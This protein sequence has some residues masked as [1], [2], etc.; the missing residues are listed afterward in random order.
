[1]KVGRNEKCP[2]GSGLKYKNC[3]MN[4]RQEVGVLRK[5]YD[6]G[7]DHDFYTRFLFGLGNIRSCAYGR[8]K[9]LEYDKS[10]NP[11]FQNLLE[12]NI[13][14]KKCVAL[15]SQ[16][17]E[18]V[19]AG[20]D[21]KYHGN[22]IDVNEPIDDE[23]NIFF[24]DFFIRGEM[25]IGSLIAH[26]RYMGSNIGFLFSNDEKKLRKGLKN[27]VLDENDERFKGL[28]AFMKH[29][30]ASWYESFN[31]LRNK[32]EHEGW[33]LPDLH[34]T[35]DANHKVQVRL[36]VAPDQ[37]IE[38]ILESYW[39]SMS[40]F[41]EEVI[42]FLLSLKL[43]DDMIIVFIPEE[44]RDK[45]LPVRYIVSPKAFPGVSLQC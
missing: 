21:G 26:S 30:R 41:C 34:Y 6:L 1:M 9:Q 43:G 44:K 31:D 4:K 16:H 20:K 15:I 33:H 12:M 25:A 11:V 10:F 40:M 22:Q 3:H 18:D 2:C 19:G 7:K 28:N 32:I 42:V 14:K 17:L 23:L 35:L 27:F 29:H 37:T 36:P 8:D 5:G 38:E 45:N 39:K 24:K 13:V